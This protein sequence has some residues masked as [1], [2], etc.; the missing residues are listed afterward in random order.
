MGGAESY[1]VSVSCVGS[2]A[3]VHGLDNVPAPQSQKNLM[4]QIP[5]IYKQHGEQHKSIQVPQITENLTNK[6]RCLP[7]MPYKLYI[8]ALVA[9]FD[10]VN[11]DGIPICCV[12][13]MTS[14]QTKH[15][16]IYITSVQINSF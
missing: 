10:A 16:R 11:T 14:A 3:S 4:E 5:G 13:G 6:R 12:T 7:I 2:P 8:V 15:L 1:R 9:F